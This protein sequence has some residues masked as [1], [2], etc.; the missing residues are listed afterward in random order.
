MQSVKKA[1]THGKHKKPAKERDGRHRRGHHEDG[2]D[3]GEEEN[4]VAEGGDTHKAP[5]LSE[6]EAELV[7]KDIEAATKDAVHGID[8]AAEAKR[9]EILA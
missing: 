3:V 8:T 7:E 4:A 2:E 1:T 9:A 6:N 5:T